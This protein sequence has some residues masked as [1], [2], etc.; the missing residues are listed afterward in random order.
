MAGLDIT[1]VERMEFDMDPGYGNLISVPDTKTSGYVMRLVRM[2]NGS[3]FMYSAKTIINVLR[4]KLSNPD[5]GEKQVAVVNGEKVVSAEDDTL[6][7][8]CIDTD[9]DNKKF[10]DEIEGPKL[11]WIEPAHGC[12]RTDPKIEVDEYKINL[13]YL[14]PNHH[15]GIHNHA[16]PEDYNVSEQM[17]EFHTTLRGGFWITKYREN[18]RR[19]EYERMHIPVGTTHPP[20]HTRKNGKIIYPWHEGITGPDGALFIAFED[21]R[22]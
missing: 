9:P 3:S 7:F 19:T 5:I 12:F 1:G 11:Y 10:F 22:T 6:L 4:G 15:G 17:I 21:Y 18:D 20:L 16:Y 13:W 8:L 2:G 14:I